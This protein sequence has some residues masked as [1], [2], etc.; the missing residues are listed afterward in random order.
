MAKTATYSLIASYTFPSAASTYTFSSIPG[1]FTDLILVGNF[2]LTTATAFRGRVNGD[3]GSNYSGTALSGN[4]TTA[5][6]QRESGVANWVIA[7]WQASAEVDFSNSVI[8]NYMDYANTTT[9]KTALARYG[10]AS[11]EVDADVLLWRNT[12]AINSITIYVASGN[13]DTGSTFKLYGI[14][15][16]SN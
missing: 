9:Y 13:I 7:G 8:I 12:A 10:S 6:S 1:T 3:T 15:A 2:K 16:G 11:K 5:V 14:L 4:G